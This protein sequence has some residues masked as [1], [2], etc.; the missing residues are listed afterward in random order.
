CLARIHMIRALIWPRK[1]TSTHRR[2]RWF[3]FQDGITRPADQTGLGGA[4]TPRADLENSFGGACVGQAMVDGESP[5]SAQNSAYIEPASFPKCRVGGPALMAGSNS[6]GVPAGS[7]VAST[8]WP[9]SLQPQ[10]LGRSS[11]G[12]PGIY[13]YGQ[14]PLNSSHNRNRHHHQI[15][16]TT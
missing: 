2:R 7:S 12:G 9:A 15:I 6:T 10:H 11:A 8:S 3:D 14:H 5:T 13:S 1:S 16:T 4:E